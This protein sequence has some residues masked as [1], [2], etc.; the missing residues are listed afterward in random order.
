VILGPPGSGKGTQAQ[1]LAS[2]TGWAWFSTGD[3]LR[4]EIAKNTARAQSVRGYVET[5]GLVPDSIILDL[6]SEFLEQTKNGS[7][8]FDGFPRTV[9]QAV[10]LDR[11]LDRP[12]DWAIFIDLPGDEVIARL[13]SRWI[14]GQCGEVYNAITSPPKQSGVCDRCQ[15][16]LKLRSDD[17]EAVI[18]TRL[19]LYNQIQTDLFPYYTRQ[20]NVKKIDGRGS[21]EEVHARIMAVWGSS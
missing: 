12:L 20:G 6:A 8:V 11:L 1:L 7:V 17:K 18:K 15:G 4:Q 10:G 16:T 5:G 2:K 3:I 14:C 9:N 13:T 19:A 21:I